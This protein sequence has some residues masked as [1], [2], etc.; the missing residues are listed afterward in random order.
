M[1]SIAVPLVVFFVMLAVLELASDGR[2]LYALP[3]LLPLSL[4][5]ASVVSTF[6]R[7][8]CAI[9]DRLGTVVFSVVIL[10]LW[11]GWLALNTGH[12]M[13]LAD[14]LHR[15]HPAYIPSFRPLA[16]VVAILFTVSWFLL[17]PRNS[18]KPDGER[19]VL[20]WATGMS[21]AWGI[22]MAILVPWLDAGNSYRSMMISLNKAIPPGIQDVVGISVD[23]SPRAMLDYY[24]GVKI[25]RF[26]PK[27]QNPYDLLLVKD[28]PGGEEQVDA[29]WRKIWEGARPGDTKEVFRLYSRDEKPNGNLLITASR[30]KL[31]LKKV[32][33]LPEER[34]RRK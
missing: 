23:E 7:W 31:K 18:G 27:G 30:R 25:R 2:D 26:E 10:T 6:P 9:L 33:G 29:G 11:A 17:V 3:L 12:P 20:S 5:A 16:F 32:Q 13:A 22:A 34:P 19:A 1:T 8:S 21:L 4:V 24:V 15:T 28:N 14:W